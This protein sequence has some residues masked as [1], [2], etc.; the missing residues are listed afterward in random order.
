MSGV[1]GEVDHEHP[2][3]LV[4]RALWHHQLQ[5]H[6]VVLARAQQ[7]QGGGGSSVLSD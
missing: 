6:T 5:T 2:C 1:E 7:L 4:G 3:L